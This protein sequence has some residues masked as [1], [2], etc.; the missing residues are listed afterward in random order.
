MLRWLG[1][2]AA[3]RVPGECDDA[4]AAEGVE[5]FVLDAER[6]YGAGQLRE[7]AGALLVAGRNAPAAMHDAGTGDAVEGLVA[8]AKITAT[9]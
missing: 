4:R 3:A 6:S 1:Y 8:L 9:Q 5:A 2:G 7:I